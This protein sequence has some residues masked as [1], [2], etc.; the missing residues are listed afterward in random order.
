M[1]KVQSDV[2]LE[3]RRAIWE[4]GQKHP[5]WFKNAR[6]LPQRVFGFLNVFENLV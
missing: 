1:N 6:N 4:K 3:P 5:A 2:S